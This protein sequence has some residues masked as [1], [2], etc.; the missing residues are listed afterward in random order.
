MSYPGQF[1]QTFSTRGQ[2]IEYP[3]ATENS[4]G[5]DFGTDISGWTMNFMAKK[6]LTDLDAAAT[7][8]LTDI[9][10][11][12]VTAVDGIGLVLLTEA[13]TDIEE[14]KYY[15]E[16]QGVDGGVVKQRWFCRLSIIHNVVDGA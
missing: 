12:V 6:D 15:G 11:G 13:L 16:V 10:A 3:R 4:F 14:G 9:T 8:P 7:I 2:I 5:Y 1:S